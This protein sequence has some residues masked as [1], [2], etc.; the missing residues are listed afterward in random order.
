[1]LRRLSGGC[2]KSNPSQIVD[3]EVVCL[4]DFLVNGQT[5]RTIP[6]VSWEGLN[7]EQASYL[8]GEETMVYKNHLALRISGIRSLIDRVLQ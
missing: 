5:S 1:V 8:E 2:A 6:V 7:I 3:G 4:S